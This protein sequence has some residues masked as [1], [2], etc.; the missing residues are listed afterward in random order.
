M[1]DI[2][3]ALFE[4]EESTEEIRSQVM[5]GQEVAQDTEPLMPE[6]AEC[7]T[8]AGARDQ[9]RRQVPAAELPPEAENRLTYRKARGSKRLWK[10]QSSDVDT[11]A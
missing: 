2:K 8:R 4:N 1:T 6:Q 10:G 9:S 3:E 11:A 7:R 5:P